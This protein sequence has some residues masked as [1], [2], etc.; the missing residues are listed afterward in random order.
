MTTIAPLIPEYWRP[1]KISALL[2]GGANYESW[3]CEPQACLCTSG[4]WKYVNPNNPHFKYL[5]DTEPDRLAIW[6]E[7]NE[8]LIST[9]MQLID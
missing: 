8:T 1:P 7:K 5:L 9:L 4:V 2:K 3:A 6:Q